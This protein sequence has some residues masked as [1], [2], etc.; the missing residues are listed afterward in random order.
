MALGISFITEGAIP[1]A[2]N[3]PL[4]VIPSL[5]L[6]S[7]TGAALSMFFNIGLLAP[8]GGIFVAFIPNAII[9]PLL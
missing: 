2:A 3:D 8:H 6:G 1:V 9:Q 7:A 5:M 4:R